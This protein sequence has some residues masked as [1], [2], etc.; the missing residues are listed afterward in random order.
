VSTRHAAVNGT[1]DGGQGRQDPEP[2]PDMNKLLRELRFGA[3]VR[4][5]RQGL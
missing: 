5:A 2:K 1:A 3:Q 4:A